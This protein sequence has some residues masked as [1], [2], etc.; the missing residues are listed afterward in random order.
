MAQK[1]ANALSRVSSRTSVVSETKQ[2]QRRGSQG[3]AKG[4]PISS[5]PGRVPRPLPPIPQD[6]LDVNIEAIEKTVISLNFL[7]RDLENEIRKPDGVISDQLSEEA[8]HKRIKHFTFR[9]QPMTPA[10]MRSCYYAGRKILK[11]LTSV[12]SALVKDVREGR[13]IISKVNFI[14]RA[15]DIFTFFE[16]KL[17]L[18]MKEAYYKQLK[19]EMT[20]NA[21][22]SPGF[23]YIKVTGRVANLGELR[24]QS[25]FHT[26]RIANNTDE[27][28]EG[29]LKAAMEFVCS[30]KDNPNYKSK[31]IRLIEYLKAEYEGRI[32]PLQ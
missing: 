14:F 8:I 26:S 21:V 30:T 32:Q 6:E 13:L 3:S 17:E 10:L 4:L 19:H 29:Y 28:R 23:D 1:N 2:R 7:I 9:Q 22:K 12:L 20:N 24:G 25:D 5:S 11:E 18:S 16:L 27:K 31:R 15:R